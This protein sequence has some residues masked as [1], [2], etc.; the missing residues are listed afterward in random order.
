MS[1]EPEE[2]IES[3]DLYPQG[4]KWYDD[5]WVDA[6]YY[7]PRS[8]HIPVQVH[9]GEVAGKPVNPEFRITTSGD[10]RKVTW[11]RKVKITQGTIRRLRREM[12]VEAQEVEAQG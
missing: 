12:K 1:T 4:V 9:F 5:K 3:S 10:W 6:N 7:L 2:D 11:W 8:I